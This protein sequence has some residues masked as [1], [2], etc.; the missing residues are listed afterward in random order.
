MQTESTNLLW[1][2]SYYDKLLQRYARRL[3]NDAAA[4][5]IIVKEV[6]EVQYDLNGLVPAKHLRQVLKTDVLNRCFYWKQSRIFHKPPTQSTGFTY[7]NP[8]S[9][10][11]LIN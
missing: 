9:S 7:W 8:D 1:T 5:A 6:L 2:V 11:P 3:V 4:A 10:N